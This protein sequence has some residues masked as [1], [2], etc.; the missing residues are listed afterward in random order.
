MVGDK[1]SDI[2]EFPGIKY[3]VKRSKYTD[4]T[5]L[6]AGAVAVNNLYEVVEHLK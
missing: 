6:K 3:F 4:G 5:N 1:K 2:L